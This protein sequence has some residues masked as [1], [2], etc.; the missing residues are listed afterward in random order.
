LYCDFGGEILKELI[1]KIAAWQNEHINSF[2]ETDEDVLNAFR[3]KREHIAF[4]RKHSKDLAI[5]LNLDEHLVD[6]AELIGLC[7]DLGR[8]YQYDKYQTFND[9]KSED[10]GALALEVLEDCPY[11]DDIKP[12]DLFLIRFAIF[13]HNKRE[14]EKTKHKNAILLAKIIRD[15]DKLDI[16][17][18]LE[19]YLTG[20]DADG[21]PN[22]VDVDAS[23]EISPEFMDLFLEGKQADYRLIKTHGDRK[24][25]RLLW[26]YDINFPWTMRKI[27]EAGY[28]EKIVE[29]LYPKN[30]KLDLAVKKLYNYMEEKMSSIV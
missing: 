22:F 12:D 8:F 9:S 25:V 1:K 10:H 24:L 16:Y 3:L 4:V 21:A 14:I 28:A 7:H 2:H 11:R 26:I 17:R 20:E 29:S 5:S 6:L 13:N 15:A 19:P 18:V 23:V 27:K 30:E